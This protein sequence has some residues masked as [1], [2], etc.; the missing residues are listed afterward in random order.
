MAFV[1]RKDAITGGEIYHIQNGVNGIMYEKDEDLSAIMLDAFENRI[2]YI[3][4][5]RRAMDYYYSKATNEIK[6]EG[7]IDAINYVIS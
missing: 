3:D 1:S 6:A 4:M 5:G 7:V 2:K